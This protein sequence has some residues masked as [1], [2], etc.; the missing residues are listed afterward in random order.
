MTSH[1]E[2]Q[3]EA[4]IAAAKAKTQQR[5]EQRD[6][7][8]AARDRGLEARKATKLRR[9][10]CATCAKLQ[11]RGSYLRCPLGCGDV[12]CRRNPRCGNTHL[13]QCDNRPTQ[14]TEGNLS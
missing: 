9:L 1:V 12:V 14:A 10:Y 7:L 13:R 3:I 5:R 8:G 6:E 2:Q 4:R 11:R